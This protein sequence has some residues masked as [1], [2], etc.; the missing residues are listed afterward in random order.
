MREGA[1]GIRVIVSGRLAGAE[2]ART[3]RDHEGKIPLQTL[4]ADIDYG[5]A[6]S[7]TTYGAIG[8]RI[9]IYRGDVLPEALPKVPKL[10][11]VKVTPPKERKGWRRVGVVTRPEGEEAEV[12]EASGTAPE[13]EIPVPPAE[14]EL[15]GGEPAIEQT[16]NGTESN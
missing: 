5:Y 13:V 8:V 9:W 6:V 4:R 12:G 15:S 14:V 10:E 7:R 1:K 3:Y 11:Q 16:E 2:I